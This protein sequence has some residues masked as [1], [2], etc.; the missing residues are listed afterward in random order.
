LL[1][2]MVVVLVLG[3]LVPGQPVIHILNMVAVVR[4]RRIAAS[5]S[6]SYL[7]T[8]SIIEDLTTRKKN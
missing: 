8:V 6:Q 1:V 4:H 2:V 3:A 5:T 7:G